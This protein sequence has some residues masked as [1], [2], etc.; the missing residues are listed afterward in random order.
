[1]PPRKK[2]SAP[3]TADR[4]VELDVAIAYLQ[5]RRDAQPK[6]AI[7][8]RATLAQL[9]DAFERRRTITLENLLHDQQ[10]DCFNH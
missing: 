4:L 6:S 5:A 2:R 1:M 9:I 10:S 7:E 3:N 8:R